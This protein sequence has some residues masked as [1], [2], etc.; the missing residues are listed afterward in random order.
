MPRGNQTNSE[1][2]RKEIDQLLTRSSFCWPILIGISDQA[3]WERTCKAFTILAKHA[4]LGYITAACYNDPMQFK[5]IHANNRLKMLSGRKCGPP[6]AEDYFPFRRDSQRHLIEETF[7]VKTSR[8]LDHQKVDYDDLNIFCITDKDDIAYNGFIEGVY[9]A[10][11]EGLVA[12]IYAPV[13]AAL[14]TSTFERSCRATS[15]L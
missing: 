4:P 15:G 6:P 8:H 2:E 12:S 13:N 9:F 5:V 10:K 14:K 1:I 11:I 3:H 7:R